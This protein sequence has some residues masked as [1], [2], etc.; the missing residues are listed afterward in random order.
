LISPLWLIRPLIRS[1]I[2]GTQPNI[3]LVGP[4]RA[5]LYRGSG[6]AGLKSRGCSEP[7]LPT[8]NP[9]QSRGSR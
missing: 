8:Y 2:G 6:G 4:Y 9:N 3:W 5:A 1:L 7:P